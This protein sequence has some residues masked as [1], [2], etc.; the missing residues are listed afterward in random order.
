MVADTQNHEN[1]ERDKASLC[2]GPRT[3]FPRYGPSSVPKS[4]TSPRGPIPNLSVN[5]I[6]LPTWSKPLTG[7]FY[8]DPRIRS[9]ASGTEAPKARIKQPSHASFR[10]RGGIITLSLGTTGYVKETPK[11]LVLVSSYTGNITINLSP[12][13]PIKPR[14]E[15][16]VFSRREDIVLSL[17]DSFCG[18]IH[19]RTRRGHLQFL[20]AI[21]AIMRVLNYTDDE[22][23][24][25]LGNQT[26]SKS[27]PRDDETLDI[28]RLSPADGRLI[29]GLWER[30][31]FP[32]PNVGFWRKLGSMF[33]E[34][35]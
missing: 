21:A 1:Q 10:T 12:A 20:P 9:L 23:L 22:A 18:M 30:D 17:P 7:S 8:I 34:T 19:M 13:L 27:N 32:E 5:Q 25:L 29:L 31:K 33:S 35:S 26:I 2:S 3:Q 28:C 6:H 14:I 24:I 15:L 16:E 11:A 4:T